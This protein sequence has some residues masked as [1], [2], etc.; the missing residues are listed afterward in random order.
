MP[1]PR[2]DGKASVQPERIG[3]KRPT[4]NGNRTWQV[5]AYA[6]TPGAPHGRVVYRRPGTTT[7]TSSV[8]V[9]GQTLDE[10]FDVVERALDQ[11]VALGTPLAAA[12]EGAPAVPARRDMRALGALYLHHLERTLKRDP[13][14]IAN[15]RSQL[16][17]WVLPV[18]GDVL[19]SDWA[20]DHNHETD[21]GTAV[22]GKQSSPLADVVRAL[23]AVLAL[24]LALGWMC[25]P[26][27]AA[28]SWAW[29][30]ARW[31]H[32]ASAVIGTPCAVLC[33]HTAARAGWHGHWWALAGWV[34]A[35][36]VLLLP[37]AAVALRLRLR[38]VATRVAEGTANPVH[39]DSV[40]RAIEEALTVDALHKAAGGK[41][42]LR[43]GSRCSA[44]W[45]SAICATL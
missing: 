8:P 22:N 28:R 44:S 37:M 1:R 43:G 10:L 11:G 30:R 38:L 40:R 3:K 25:A 24:P 41:P 34:V 16:T 31:R 20:P 39:A 45:R 17:K 5:R 12:A 21:G 6:P 19:V 9:E 29:R 13:D 33:W 32:P 7:Q 4:G 26:L 15:R 35:A 23:V 36:W 42:L 27:L 2:K 18:I 14:Y